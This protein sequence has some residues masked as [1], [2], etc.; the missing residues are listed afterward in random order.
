MDEYDY[1]EY[2]SKPYHGY[3]NELVPRATSEAFEDT[4]KPE[5]G[6]WERVERYKKPHRSSAY[7]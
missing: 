6:G 3:T 5:M 1:E 4:I 7:R 2:I